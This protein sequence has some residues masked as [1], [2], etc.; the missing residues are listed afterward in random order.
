MITKIRL[1]QGNLFAI[2]AIGA[3]MRAHTIEL[4]VLAEKKHEASLHIFLSLYNNIFLANNYTNYSLSMTPTDTLCIEKSV[5]KF[6]AF[7]AKSQ[8]FS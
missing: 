8:T 7:I 4:C 1:F 6:N 2:S 3:M 5:G